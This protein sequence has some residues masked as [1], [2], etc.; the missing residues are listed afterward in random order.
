MEL[1]GCLAVMGE[2]P[3]EHINLDAMEPARAVRDIRKIAMATSLGASLVMLAG[4]LTAYFITGSAAIFSDAAESVIH[5]LATAF[6]GFSL[7]YAVRPPDAD[8]PYGHG[9]IAYF[10]A[11]IEGTL[12]MGA[13]LT[14]LVTAIHAL[15]VGPEL[16]QLGVGL[17]ITGGLGGI[18]LLLGIFLIRVGRRTNALVLVSNGMHV[19][20]DMWTSLGVVV[21]VA[22]VWLTDIQ[23]LDPVVAILMGMNLGWMAL[24]LMRQSYA[25]LMERADDEDT[26][27]IV[28]VLEES[29]RSGRIAGFHQLRHRRVNDQ[30]WVEYHLQFDGAR[31][32]A[33]AH[34]RS[35]AVEAAVTEL[36]PGVTVVV[37]A[38]LEP[39][40][41]AE[42]HPAGHAE[43]QDPLL[44]TE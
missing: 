3:H 22:L 43:P 10:S 5:L 7:W 40:A 13:A 25:G 19:L 11:G 18:N 2:T 26:H 41:H 31:S 32:L 1:A 28:S 30:V 29:I 20:S 6:V 15:I 33:D 44:H 16:R 4:K 9:K 14:I 8:H 34:E 37:T 42:S 38:H 17:L 39:E 23:W 12:I 21:G 35:H 36:F 24:R 27:A